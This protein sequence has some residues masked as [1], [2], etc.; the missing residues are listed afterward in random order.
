MGKI[1]FTTAVLDS[2]ETRT[3][4]GVVRG[5]G[6]EVEQE[7]MPAG[8]DENSNSSNKENGTLGDQ[9][10]VEM[11]RDGPPCGPIGAGQDRTGQDR[12]I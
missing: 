6:R 9:V 12:V 3:W 2:Q 10:S 7:K 1:L 8:T 11:A 4:N 5:P